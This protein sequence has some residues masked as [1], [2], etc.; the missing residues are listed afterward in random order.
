[1]V[2]FIFPDPGL[3]CKVEFLYEKIIVILVV[4]NSSAQPYGGVGANFIP[5][6]RS[7]IGN[8]IGGHYKVN[9]IC[10]CFIILI[11]NPTLNSHFR[12]NRSWKKCA[13][14][15]YEFMYHTHKSR[16]MFATGWFLRE[17]ACGVWVVIVVGCKKKFS[18]MMCVRNRF[19]SE[20]WKYDVVFS[21]VMSKLYFFF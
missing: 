14:S 15:N 9:T 7:S 1:M 11:C 6:F 17:N 10:V 2:H 18:I 16:E 8:Y 13:F 21:S 4:Q 19:F 3:I 20:F 5:I 12:K